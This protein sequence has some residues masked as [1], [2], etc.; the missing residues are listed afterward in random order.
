M[1]EA[2]EKNI[3]IDAIQEN[4]KLFNESWGLDNLFLV[5]KEDLITSQIETNKKGVKGKEEITKIILKNH[6]GAEWLLTTEVNLWK[7]W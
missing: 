3:N 5:N 6:Q 2:K 1:V 4:A 7:L